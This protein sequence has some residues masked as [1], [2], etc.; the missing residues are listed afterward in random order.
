MQLKERRNYVLQWRKTAI[1]LKV[2][3]ASHST[4]ERGSN[5]FQKTLNTV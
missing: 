5:E 2:S 1:K 3:I 4:Y